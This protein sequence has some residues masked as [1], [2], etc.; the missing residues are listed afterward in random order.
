M[1]VVV[2]RELELV[3]IE[4]VEVQSQRIS[5]SSANAVVKLP[6]ADHDH[7]VVGILLDVAVGV[8]NHQATIG[9]GDIVSAVA[10]VEDLD[11]AVVDVHFHVHR[12]LF[13]A[14]AATN[15]TLVELVAV[16]VTITFWNVSTSA[17]KNGTWATTHTA[18][19][20][21]SVSAAFSRAVEVQ[22]RPIFDGVAVVVASSFVGAT[23]A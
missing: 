8:Q 11:D 15:A 20:E 2:D 7:F 1:A 21:V 18:L 16:A 3:A 23:S 13:N 14:R 4:R 9:E 17:L 22:A 19:V 10:V 5:A 12:A 6:H